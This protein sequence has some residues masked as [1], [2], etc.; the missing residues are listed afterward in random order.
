MLKAL[1]AGVFMAY[2]LIFASVLLC[3]I[4]GLI[5]WNKGGNV[6]PE[7]ASEE[8]KWD[9]EEKEITDEIGG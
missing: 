6:T 5:N 9:Q 8:S 1:D 4:Y 7:E 3:I 2:L